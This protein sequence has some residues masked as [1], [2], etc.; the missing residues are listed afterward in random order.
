MT[1]LSSMKSLVL[2]IL[3][4]VFALNH[5]DALVFQR[6]PNVSPLLSKLDALIESTSS[7]PNDPNTQEEIKAMMVNISESR[8]GDQRKKLPGQWELIFTTE[9]EV[10]FFKTSWPFASVSDIVQDLD[11]YNSQSIDNSINFETGGKFAV[12]GTAKAIDGDSEF[13]RVGFEFK[14]AAITAWDKTFQIPPVGAGWF[15]T[16]Y[17]DDCYRLSQDV[18]GDWS[19]FRRR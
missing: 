1:H 19:V 9:K 10:N 8:Q 2:A 7:N 18:R 3:A 6:A 12:T 5:V 11:L 16:M 14:S 13:D 17:C 4:L 15:D